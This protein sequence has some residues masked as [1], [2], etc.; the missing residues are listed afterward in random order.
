MKRLSAVLVLFI[1]LL[2]ACSEEITTAPGDAS[3]YEGER[4]SD[5]AFY[6]VAFRKGDVSLA[7]AFDSVLAEMISDGSAGKICE[8]Y[9]GEDDIAY[10]APGHVMPEYSSDASDNSFKEIADA[11][12]IIIGYQDSC[13]PMAWR[14]AYGTVV[15]CDVD[16]AYEA[17]RRLGISVKFEEIDWSSKDA[18]LTGG[19]VDA[20]FC[21]Y[22]WSE[23]RAQSFALTR[24]YLAVN[25]QLLSL[26]DNPVESLSDLAE[27][28]VGVRKGSE[29]E[30]FLNESGIAFEK[31]LP[32]D[33]CA[34][35][36]Y[37]MQ[38]GKID[39]IFVDEP[40]ARYA[41]SGKLVK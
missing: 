2:T 15:G 38:D 28:R 39:A 5:E 4:L 8:N 13:F 33:T 25:Y 21:A 19:K 36:Y 41:L 20:I 3:L 24:P 31:L 14:D 32:C 27:K 35:A 12:T 1:L 34:Y 10:D 40:F 11:G 9:L 29:A 6:T 30:A 37:R 26:K 17:A 23:S 22:T 16:L 7:A 18:A